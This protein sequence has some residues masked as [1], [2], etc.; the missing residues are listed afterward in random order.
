MSEKEISR[1]DQ[2]CISQCILDHW[3]ENSK[4]PLE[5]RDDEYE[6]CLSACRICS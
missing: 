4:T 1:K 5:R 3:S 6:R 2:K